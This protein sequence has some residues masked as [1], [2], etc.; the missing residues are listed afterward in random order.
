MASLPA[1]EAI[2]FG[3]VF[4]III[5][6]VDVCVNPGRYANEESPVAGA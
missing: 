5:V 4:V 2:L 6:L 3:G 1:E